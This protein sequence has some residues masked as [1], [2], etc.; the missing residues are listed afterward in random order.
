MKLRTILFTTLLL[1]MVLL[2][3][4]PNGDLENWAGGL[5]VGWTA[6]NSPGYTYVA[7]S[8]V[9]YTG[10]SSAKLQVVT[11]PGGTGCVPF[12]G[13]VTPI[14][15]IPT[16]FSFWYQF[17][18][19][20]PGD[21][22]WLQATVFEP[23]YTTNVGRI[24]TETFVPTNTWMHASLPWEW[25]LNPS[26][27][28][29]VRFTLQ[30]Q[31]H[32]GQL[33]GGTYALFDQFSVEVPVGVEEN[34]PAWLNTSA[35]PTPAIDEVHIGFEAPQAGRAQISLMDLA[36]RVLAHQEVA[37]AKAGW[38]VAHFELSAFAAGS[39]IAMVKIGEKRAQLR[40][41]VVK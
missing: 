13:P 33:N 31:S 25:V 1:P 38:E 5:P 28:D 32:L 24:S 6:N 35:Y 27:T 14:H 41:Q 22:I 8:S 37:V 26:N 17:V 20:G 12:T 21:S 29:T 7:Q 3:Q 4:V 34:H 23:T 11:Y 2:A 9:A 18:Q 36:G 16:S 39:Y 40:I 19:G 15:G 10:N 30:L